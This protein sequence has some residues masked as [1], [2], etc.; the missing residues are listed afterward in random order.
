VVFTAASL[1]GGLAS[2]AGMLLA[3]RIAQGLGAAAA[4]P[5]TLALITTTFTEPVRRIRALSIFSG[6]T[7]GGFA[8]GLMLGGLLTEWTSWRAVL[9]INVPVGIA[10]VA[11]A[12]RFLTEPV[13]HPGRLDLPGAVVATAGVGTLVYGLIRAA[14]AGWSAVG[15]LVPLGAGVVLLAGF[16]LIE[17]R[18]AQP[19]MPLRLFANRDRAAGYLSF[20][21]GP[22][23]MMSSFFFMTQFLQN[24]RGLSPLATGFA[25]LPMAVALFT[26]TRLLPWLLPR[27]G[28]KPLTMTGTALLTGGVL[29]LT[30][31][32]AASGYFPGVFLPFLLLG[33][34]GG[35]A[36]SPLNVVVMA[37]VPASDAGAA[38]GVLQTMQ[39]L[40][41]TVGLAILIT[42][43]GTGS[44][45]AL[46]G[47]A[48]ASHAL[49]S[50]MTPAFAV[51]A[52]F[53]AVS[54]LVALTFR[55]IPAR[56][57]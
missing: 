4:G 41:A 34:G 43:F 29:L 28:P 33:I 48:D 17:S 14:S 50:G 44:R 38:G 46:A 37:T 11:L 49:V 20:F 42:V 12:L 2:S 21:L 36:F 23:A 32:T 47:G 57:V 22:M 40:G 15:T 5:N 55:K 13:R 26:M 25:F 6:T 3:A 51:A 39:N 45:H 1:A 53:G 27:F 18:T 24:V 30:R 7:V 8:I 52:G 10:V 56:T 35:L 31:L 54:F 19:L 9:F 16:V